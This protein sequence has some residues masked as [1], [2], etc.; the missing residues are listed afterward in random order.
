MSQSVRRHYPA[1][2]LDRAEAKLTDILDDVSWPDGDEVL[3]SWD[4]MLEQLRSKGLT[5]GLV[6]L[7]PNPGLQDTL[8]STC[9][10]EASCQ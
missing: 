4:W 10:N 5:L 1:E 6:E 3:I 8:P 7:C 9:E 2:K